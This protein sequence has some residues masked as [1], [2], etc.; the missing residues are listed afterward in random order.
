MGSAEPPV[1]A[2]Y[3]TFSVTIREA[4]DLVRP[5]P[6]TAIRVHFGPRRKQ[7]PVIHDDPA[8]VWNT[9]LVFPVAGPSAGCRL[10]L[11]DFAPGN[12]E[13]IG[14][15]QT[16]VGVGDAKRAQWC[17]LAPAGRVRLEYEYEFDEQTDPAER[18]YGA[19]TVEVVKAKALPVSEFGELPDAY[20]VLEYGGPEQRTKLKRNTCDPFW[21][22]A[23]EFQVM[24]PDDRVTAT[25]LSEDGVVFSSAV[26]GVEFGAEAKKGAEWLPL[27]VPPEAAQPDGT[28]PELQLRYKFVARKRKVEEG[29]KKDEDVIELGYQPRI[30]GQVGLIP[31]VRLYAWY[32]LLQDKGFQDNFVG[33]LLGSY[34]KRVKVRD[35]AWAEVPY[36]SLDS[37]VEQEWK[38]ETR[39][40]LFNKVRSAAHKFLTAQTC[41]TTSEEEARDWYRWKEFSVMRAELATSHKLEKALRKMFNVVT[42]GTEN[43][44]GDQR[45]GPNVALN[46]RTHQIWCQHV[47][48]A[49]VPGLSKKLARRIAAED[50]VRYGRAVLGQQQPTATITSAAAATTQ[51]QCQ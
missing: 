45:N 16:V 21:N 1:F 39:L 34:T 32:H 17:E 30:N 15:W 14:E 6:S 44:S 9:T 31:E 26:L 38:C 10:E 12:P 13:R 35:K 49:F 28:V 24:D 19:V 47:Y 22:E 50:F 51:Q 42:F 5:L 4:T 3:G 7:T 29:K 46:R 40:R 20:V 37:L 11:W 18:S 41:F 36:E 33:A 48:C 25:V 43:P 23:F 8:P 2:G 27:T